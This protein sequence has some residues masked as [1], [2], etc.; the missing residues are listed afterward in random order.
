VFRVF[1]RS[2]E[3][4]YERIPHIRPDTPS[5]RDLMLADEI[6]TLLTRDKIH[7]DMEMSRSKLA[8][9]LAVTEHNLS[10]IINQCFE[11]N[12]SSLLNEHRVI[13]AKERLERETTAITIIAFEVGFSSIPSFNRVFKQS[14]GMSPS[15][16]RNTLLAAKN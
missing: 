8:S 14:V 1:D 13:E 10:R 7:R 12:F 11:Q 6:R 16:Y 4:A 2:F 5:V 15:E 9:K 3:I